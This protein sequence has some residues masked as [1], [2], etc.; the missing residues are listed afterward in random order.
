MGDH[1]PS[2]IDMTRDIQDRLD[3]FEADVYVKRIAL[4]MD[5]IDHYAPPP[6][7]TKLSDARASGYIKNYGHEC[8][9]L[10]A[11]EPSVIT[12]LI[13][14]EVTAL[15]DEDVK[16]R[17]ESQE[18]LDKRTLGLIEENYEEVMDFVMDI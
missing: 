17:V 12:E 6:N 7:P 9:E 14:N 1:D 13:K 5:Q 15:I 16:R 10:D 18:D 11:L 4:T 2:G 3:L 8:W